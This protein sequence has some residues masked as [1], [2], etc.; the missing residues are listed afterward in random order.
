MT[1]RDNTMS[2]TNCSERNETFGNL[3]RGPALSELRSNSLFINR[4]NYEMTHHAPHWACAWKVVRNYME[5]FSIRFF[6]F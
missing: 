4:L 5:Q 6:R 2:P 1:Y 3:E